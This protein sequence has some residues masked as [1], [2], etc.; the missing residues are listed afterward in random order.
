MRTIWK[1]A[2]GLAL[3]LV[4]VG[5]SSQA[6][7]RSDATVPVNA[8]PAVNINGQDAM[9][10][11]MTGVDSFFM[12]E[13][14]GTAVQ[15]SAWPMPMVMT[16]AGAWN[17]MWMGQAFLVDTQQTGPLGYDKLYSTNW[18]ML[19]AMHRLGRGGIMLRAM[20]SLEPA[21]ITDRRYPLLFQTGE[22]AYGEPITNAQHPHNLVM[23]LSAQ[24]SHSVGEHATADLY[25]G[26]VGD[27]ALGPVA[28]PHR[29]S[30]MEIPQATLGHHWEDST[31]IAS[32]VLTGV[33]AFRLIRFEASGFYGVEPG[34]NRWT[35][36]FG[37]MNSY[38]GRIT[39]TP[40]SRWA[41]QVSAG[42][43]SHPEA[44]EP[45][46]V[47]RTTA[48]VEY[49]VPRPG[50]NWWATSLIW[51]RNWKIAPQ[52]GTNA[53]LAETV[54]PFRGKNFLTARYEWSQR[55][56][57]FADNPAMEEQFFL[58]TGAR[59]FDVNAYTFGYTHDL[60][61]RHGAETGLGANISV[62]GIP[63][64]IEPYYGAHPLGVNV[65]LRVR[66]R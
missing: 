1:L 4:P 42:H 63:A 10:A 43:L 30:A 54:V 65:Y 37:P 53:V 41:A 8:H 34:E 33:L 58:T 38:S 14:S 51:G 47:V 32:N 23:E 55:D 2:V 61:T 17:L 18:G 5:V 45:G 11:R 7:E 3:L 39:F 12:G 44:L 20:V 56:E 49:V 35:I 36:Y 48:S 59:W 52:Y 26:V 13:S 50:G 64:A 29:A 60:F 46:D 6:P 24:Y 57:L 9:G 25:Y 15:P 19:G 16:N 28:Y 22:T 21:T 31:H 27:P 62:Y 66:L 40:T